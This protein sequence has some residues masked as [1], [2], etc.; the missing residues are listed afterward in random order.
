MISERGDRIAK[1][2]GNMNIALKRRRGH[3]NSGSISTGGHSLETLLT[4]EF[5]QSIDID[6]LADRI[7][8]ALGE[9][10]E[11]CLRRLVFTH[12]IWEHSL[13]CTSSYLEDL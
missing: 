13:E 4:V 3:R 9:R 8:K 5:P 7:V 10:N 6:E 1:K 12:F 2:N 11:K